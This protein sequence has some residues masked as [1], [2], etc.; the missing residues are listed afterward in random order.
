MQKNLIVV[1][2]SRGIGLAVAQFYQA[3][4][5]NVF[6]VSRTPSTIGRWIEADMSNN[7]GI[8]K[9]LHET[10]DHTIDAL[11]YMGGVWE[12]HAFT[13]NYDFET[14]PYSETHNIININQIA[15]IELVKG[16]LKSLKKSRN[17]RAVFIGATSGL[18]IS[19]TAEVAYSASKFG[20]RGAVHALRI[21]CNNQGIGFT[22]INPGLVG[23]DEVLKDIKSSPQSGLIPIPIDDVVRAVDFVLQSSKDTE[24]GDITLTQKFTV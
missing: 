18:D 19:S 12:E 11:L 14:S 3:K 1:G 15:P 5:D 4:G 16:L 8:Q 24:I 17:P 22:T 20:L 10:S 2:A 13:E 21:G 7:E 23:T 9:V 6:S